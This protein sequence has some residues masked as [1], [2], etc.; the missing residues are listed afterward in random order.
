[1]SDQ[2]AEMAAESHA[3]ALDVI[4][5]I[6]TNTGLEIRNIFEQDLT[7]DEIRQ[8]MHTAITGYVEARLATEEPSEDWPLAGQKID[9]REALFGVGATNVLPNVALTEYNYNILKT[10]RGRAVHDY[11]KR[12]T[13]GL[14]LLRE[15]MTPGEAA[16]TIVGSGIAAFATA[17]I[18]GTVKALLSG[19][20]LRAAVTAGVRAM[21]KLSIIVGVALVLITE[22][23]LYLMFANK[24]VFLGIIFNNTPLNL[25]VHGWRNGVNGADSGDLFMNT[26]STTAFMETNMTDRLNSPLVQILAKFAVED[27]EDNIVSGGI[28]CASKKPGLFGTEGAMVLSPYNRDN[29]KIL[30]RFA[31]V[32]ACPYTGDNGVNVQ[33]DEKDII[34]AK[35]H[36]DN[37][38]KSR[39]QHRSATGEGY[40]FAASSSS[41]KGGEAAGIATLDEIPA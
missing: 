30:P 35:R 6:E 2:E 16:A 25:V 21:G 11:V 10:Y 20:A 24:K 1:M 19:Q 23:L 12:V 3:F 28:F 17:M 40:T 4:A 32:F 7:P 14:A 15:G 41:P 8:Q 18:V 38:Y 22:L 34:S 31:L 36:F 26:G 39:G 9:V 29:Q 27:P 37:L 33:V 13:N 5:Q